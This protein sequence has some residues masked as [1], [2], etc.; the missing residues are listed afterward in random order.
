ML[1][2]NVQNKEWVQDYIYGR[3]FIDLIKDFT[4]VAVT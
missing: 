2:A 3:D 4:P 1:N